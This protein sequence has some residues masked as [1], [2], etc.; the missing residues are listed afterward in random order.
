MTATSRPRSR[1][2]ILGAGAMGSLFAY[3]FAEHDDVTLVDVRGDVVDTINA[4]GGVRVDDLPVRRVVATRDAAAAFKANYLFVF[5]K[6]PNT[7]A[8]VRPFAGMLNP[9]TPIVSLQN[10]LGNEEAI[11]TALGGTV[12]LVIGVTDVVGLAV[13]HGHSRRQGI[14]STV[15]GT[16]GATT[17]SVRSVQQLIER[18]HLDCGIAYDIQPHL[19]GKLL[20]NAAIN[21]IAALAEASNDIIANDA[22]AAELARSVAAEGAEIARAL[23]VN[24]PFGD[25]WEYV[26]G[27]VAQTSGVR[28]SMTIDL[29]ARM[30]TEID[31]VNGA[32]VAAA[33]RLGIRTPYNEALVRLVRAK[34]NASRD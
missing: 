25:T 22:D 29:A 13:G 11:K 33:R 2:A 3:H 17:A 28:N 14:G 16:A 15:V 20:A 24:L 19:W 23:R 4:V 7:L 10:G 18:A 30:T 26:R 1:V 9:A 12:S 34:Q 6:A 31:Q 8:A 21:P 32:I 27:V 5:V